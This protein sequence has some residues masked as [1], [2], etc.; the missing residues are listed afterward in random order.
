M[1]DTNTMSEREGL[2]I[3]VTECTF[4]AYQRTQKRPFF[5]CKLST[6]ILIAIE[7]TCI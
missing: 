2:W 5:A 3:F 1:R 7:V 6:S 4:V